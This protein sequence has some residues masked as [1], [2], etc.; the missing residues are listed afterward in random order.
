MNWRTLHVAVSQRVGFG[1]DKVNGTLPLGDSPGA[2]RTPGTTHSLHLCPF[3]KNLSGILTGG[4]SFLHLQGMV[5]SRH[6]SVLT[7]G[8]K[9]WVLGTEGGKG[10]IVGGLG[11]TGKLLGP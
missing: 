7:C 6:I 5:G 10:Q 1:N 8:E 3:K 4:C 2:L 9:G 11:G